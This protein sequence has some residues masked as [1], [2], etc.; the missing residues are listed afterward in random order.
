MKRN[1]LIAILCIALLVT[2]VAPVLAADPPDKNN[3]TFTGEVAEEGTRIPLSATL[4]A[5]GG[6]NISEDIIVGPF[7]VS[8]V[9]QITSEEIE[10]FSK[11]KW[12]PGDKLAEVTWGVQNLTN[13]TKYI[14]QYAWSTSDSGY[15]PIR[16]EY[17]VTGAGGRV[18]SWSDKFAIDGDGEIMLTATIYLAYDAPAAKNAVVHVVRPRLTIPPT[19]ATEG[20][21]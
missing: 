14:C 20:K 6:I 15:V 2:G 5:A 1:I 7:D 8:P 18:S 17:N 12:I 10:R 9:V 11:E 4:V 21:G 16:I 3:V 13:E 19:E